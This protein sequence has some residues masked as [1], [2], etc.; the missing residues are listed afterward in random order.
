VHFRAVDLAEL[1]AFVAIGDA[2]T[3]RVYR[4]YLLSSL[5]AGES[6]PERWFAAIDGEKI[7]GRI[8]YWSLPG[9]AEVSLDVFSLPWADEDRAPFA[10]DFLSAS[11][12][13]LRRSGVRAVEYEHHEPDPDG[14]TPQRLLATLLAA[15]FHR[16]RETVRFELSPVVPVPADSR[17]SFEGEADGRSLTDFAQV[18]RRCTAVGE[19]TGVTRRRQDEDLDVAAME[20]V[21][22]TAAMRGGQGRWRIGRIGDDVVG[23]ILPTANDGGPVLN[24]VGVV[25]EHR[26]RRIVDEL[27]AETARLQAGAGAT[28]VRADSDLDNRSMHAAFERAGWEPFGRRTTYRLELDE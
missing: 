13:P 22:S 14:H 9:V 10:S 20:F 18:V 3:A 17:V 21:S 5:A 11:L 28:R 7:V 19:D 8:V 16:A 12:E 6:S 1:D 25:P 27:L 24:Y 15:G 2:E 23:V 4:N 26:G